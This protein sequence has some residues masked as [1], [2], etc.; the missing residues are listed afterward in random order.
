[1]SLNRRFV[2]SEEKENAGRVSST[3][4]PLSTEMYFTAESFAGGQPWICS[5]FTKAALWLDRMDLFAI[6]HNIEVKIIMDL[7][8]PVKLPNKC[9]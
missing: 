7:A 4:T 3:H 2:E 8:L 1:M 5:Q 9:A 6:D